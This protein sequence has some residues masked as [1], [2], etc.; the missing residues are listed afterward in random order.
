MTKNQYRGL[1]D[2]NF[3]FMDED[4]RE[5]YGSYESF[6]EALLVCRSIVDQWLENNYQPE[7]TAA[8][9][10]NRYKDFGDDPFIVGFDIPSRFSA[11]EY[12]EQRCREIFSKK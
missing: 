11:W 7:M 10:Y 9:L 3:H 4:E 5:E 2:D 8:E 12:A 6:D 1:I